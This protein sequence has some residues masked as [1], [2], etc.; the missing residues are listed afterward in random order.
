M[1][2]DFNEL[3]QLVRPVVNDYY[4]LYRQLVQ[5]HNGDR[6]FQ[7]D[8]LADLAENI[9]SYLDPAASIFRREAEQFRTGNH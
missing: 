2:D 8:R 4:D 5:E 9:L 7:N 1:S 3:F 6:N